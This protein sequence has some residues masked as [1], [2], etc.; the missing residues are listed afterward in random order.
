ML[1]HIT[2]FICSQ[3]IIFF[4]NMMKNSFQHFILSIDGYDI[5][6]ADH[7]LTQ[8]M[9]VYVFILKGT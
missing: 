2:N 9:V 5:V 6:G 1:W 7:H 3:H 4:M 8:R